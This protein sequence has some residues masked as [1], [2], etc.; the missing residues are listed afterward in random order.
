MIAENSP[1]S[2]KRRAFLK[3]F[4]LLAAP[5]MIMGGGSTYGYSSLIE[6]HRVKV[7]RHEVRLSLGSKGPVKLRAVGLTDFHFDPLFEE[8]YLAEVVR[9]TNALKP[10]IVMLTGDYISHTSRRFE[11]FGKI[12]GGLEATCGVYA[13]LG[14]H[15]HWHQPG[16]IQEIL[17]R[18][19]IDVL[20][21]RHTRVPC[22]G[23]EVVLTGLQ[24]VWGGA[25]NWAV[26][27]KGL[28][29]DDRTLVLVHEPD[30]ATYLGGEERIVF[31]TSGHTHGGQIRLPGI[32][33]LRLP[34]WGKRYE[35]GFY[36]VKNIQLYVNRGIG[37]IQYHVRFMCPPEIACFDI[38]NSDVV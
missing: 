22:A 27:S 4:R 3:R 34:S 21:N 14:N 13:C 31:L 5:A 18:Q 7:D 12:V 28:H 9:R 24:S 10:D 26:A 25:P 17:E 8:E 30:Y 11:E 35:A 23:G 19:G 6:R 15:D 2:E 32:G 16:R 36:N 20:V 37:T 33:A 38:V 1:L 29:P